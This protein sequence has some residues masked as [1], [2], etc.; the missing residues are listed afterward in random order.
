MK[1]LVCFS[2]NEKCMDAVE[3]VQVCTL[4]I[5]YLVVPSVRLRLHVHRGRKDVRSL[6]KLQKLLLS[7]CE[8]P[9]GEIIVDIGGCYQSKLCR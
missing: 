2:W 5:I 8:L 9:I 7:Y 4:T 6:Y 1:G 3:R